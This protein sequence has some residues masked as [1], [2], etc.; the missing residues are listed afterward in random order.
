[1]FEQA[2]ADYARDFC[3][4]HEYDYD[5]DGW[6]AG[7]IGEIFMMGE[8][9]VSL[10]DI[11]TDMDMEAPKEEFAKWYDYDLL[12]GELGAST[13]NYNHW[14]MGA[15]RRSDAEIAELERLQQNIWDAKRLLEDAVRAYETN[16][17]AF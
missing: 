5:P 1:M 4:K 17:S 3:E 13:I 11:R 8:Y 7:R 15:P 16:D 14:L 10:S 12:M 6:V 9:Y 2:C